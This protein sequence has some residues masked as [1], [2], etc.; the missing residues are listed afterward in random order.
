MT[1]G[2]TQGFTLVELMIVVAIIGILASIAIPNFQRYTARARASEGKV[3]LAN[4]YTAEKSYFAANTTYTA[5]LNQIGFR[6]DSVDRWYTIGFGGTIA[7][8][9]T[10]GV[11]GGT[12][13]INTSPDANC[14]AAFGEIA[15][16]ATRSANM[17]NLSGINALSVLDGAN[18]A[19]NNT[20]FQVG[21]VGEV[22]L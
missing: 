4:A 13:C 18:S 1:Y 20:G 5:C 16:P 2:D 8:G 9:T 22:G 19:V 21:A 11:G 12:T 17:G 10:C 15:W 3:L 7:A 14:S 6:L